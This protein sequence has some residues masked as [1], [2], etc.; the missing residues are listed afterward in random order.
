MYSEYLTKFSFICNDSKLFRS[1]DLRNT[2]YSLHTI[3][4]VLGYSPSLSSAVEIELHD[5]CLAFVSIICT[6][7][8]RGARLERKFVLLYYIFALWNQMIMNRFTKSGSLRV[9]FPMLSL[10]LFIDL[11][12][13]AALWHWV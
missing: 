1:R 8:L 4:L 12:L 5:D 13:T 10:G 3:H 7:A 6:P 2:T 9:R 11:I